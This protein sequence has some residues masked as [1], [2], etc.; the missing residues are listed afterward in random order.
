MTAISLFVYGTLKPGGIYYPTYCGDRV[1]S[2]QRVYTWGMLYHLSLGYPGM[3]EGNNQV[4]GVLLTFPDATCLEAID[5]LEGYLPDRLPA[6]NEYQRCRIPVFEASDRFLTEAWGY[7]MLPDKIRQYQG[8]EI[9]SGWW[10]D[11]PLF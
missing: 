7:R 4:H 1:L 10:T 8:I 5:R 11:P 3:T 9:P 6:Q 2:S